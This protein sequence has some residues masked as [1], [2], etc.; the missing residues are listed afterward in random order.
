ML[1]RGGLKWS[2]ESCPPPRCQPHSFSTERI[3]LPRK[4]PLGG[5]SFALSP[6]LHPLTTAEKRVLR[7]GVWVILSHDV[8]TLCPGLLLS[9]GC[10]D[11]GEVIPHQGN[12]RLFFKE[13]GI[14]R[15]HVSANL[16]KRV[17]TTSCHTGHAHSSSSC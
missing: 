12:W 9:Q 4:Q 3:R 6:R 17:T 10:H 5:I 1:C 8:T 14:A 13:G 15:K 11:R 16:A 7:E 2:P